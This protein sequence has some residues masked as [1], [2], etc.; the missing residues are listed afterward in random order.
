MKNRVLSACFALAVALPAASVSF[1][2]P[3]KDSGTIC[4]TGEID[5]LGTTGKDVTWIWTLEWTFMSDDKD[6]ERAASGKC[7]G[8]G[9][10]IGG[11]PEANPY[12]CT[13]KPV[14]GG[15]Y[16]SRG[17]G[18]RGGNKT[19]FFGGTEKYEGISGGSIGGPEIQLPADKGHF[20]ACRQYDAEYTLK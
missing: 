5:R 9:A 19:E 1:A 6:P 10:L 2:E 8:S 3:V 18:G 12:F 11:K 16:M 15:S 4:F 20:A 13:H 17:V 7:F 14:G